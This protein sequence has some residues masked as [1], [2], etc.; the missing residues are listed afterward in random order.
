MRPFGRDFVGELIEERAIVET[1]EALASEDPPA[2]AHFAGEIEEQTE[3]GF[4][5]E[6]AEKI[7]PVPGEEPG[8]LEAVDSTVAVR[9]M[10]L[11]EPSEPGL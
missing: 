4:R 1:L 10:T 7:R 6:M 11:E 5:T 9:V 2:L 3:L 8:Q